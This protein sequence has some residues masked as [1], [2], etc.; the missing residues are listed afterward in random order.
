MLRVAVVDDDERDAG[1][2]EEL[3]GRYFEGDTERFL[4]TRL[5]D[6]EDLLRDYK[7]SYDLVF[8]D[9][10]M[11]RMDGLTCARRLRRI[12]REVQLVFTT[13]MAQ[14]A[15]SGYDVG[16]LGY[17]VKPLRYYSFALAMR[18]AEEV[19]ESR[20]G[21]VLWLSKGDEKVA[22]ASRDVRYVEVR[23]HEITFH[24]RD[25]AYTS[26]GTLKTFA[27]L[28]EPAH[29]VACNR[30]YLVN[31]EHVKGLREGSIVLDTGVELE[32]SRRLKRPLMQSLTDYYG[33]G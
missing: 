15:A 17:I 21:V 23:K 7:S 33:M 12:D 4:L 28:L 20:R 22:V 13:N 3:L 26:W 30:Y 24:V 8:L 25:D 29:F 1:R 5:A 18:R 6:G 2:V 9:I 32:V 31:L 10:E 14:Y 11:E 19:L 16:A 27:E